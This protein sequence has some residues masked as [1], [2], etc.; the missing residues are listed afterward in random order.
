[1][2]V[3]IALGAACLLVRMGQALYGMGLIRAKNAAGAVLRAV[4]EVS[5]G[6]L[7]FWLI[8]AAIWGGDRHWVGFASG[9][10]D[11]RLFFLA[12][13]ALIGCAIPG[14]AMAERSRFWPLGWSVALM[15]AVIIPLGARWSWNGWLAKSGFIDAGGGVWLHAAGGVCALA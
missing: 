11:G 2:D 15:G 4:C 1:M 10:V 5:A 9:G 14:A 6:M 8:G 3:M 7:G 13:V 12:T